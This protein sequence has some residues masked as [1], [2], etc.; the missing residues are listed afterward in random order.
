MAYSGSP[1]C[2]AASSPNSSAVLAAK[3]G[4]LVEIGQVALAVE[5]WIGHAF[6]V[7]SADAVTVIVSRSPA[8]S[9][10]RGV[11]QRVSTVQPNA[12]VSG[13]QPSGTDGRYRDH[14]WSAA[15]S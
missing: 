3:V 1:R 15:R 13:C 12:A 9:R 7:G 5:L 6:S 2:A 10:G 8:R 11:D 14:Q 4:R